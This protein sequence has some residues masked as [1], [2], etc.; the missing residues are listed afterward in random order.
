MPWDTPLLIPTGRKGS[1][2]LKNIVLWELWPHHLKPTST[3]GLIR[4]NLPKPA[5]LECRTAFFFNGGRQGSC[6]ETPFRSF[7]KMLHVQGWSVPLE[8]CR[9]PLEAVPSCVPARMIDFSGQALSPHV[10]ALV[11]A[12]CTA[13][14]CFR[15]VYGS[16]TFEPEANVLALQLQLFPGTQSP[17][18]NG[19][20]YSFKCLVLDLNIFTLKS[21][22][23]WELSRAD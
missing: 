23:T 3:S 2:C 22:Q 21:W 18:L 5:A 14:W 19:L 11:P 7:I 15:R 13:L 4:K 16:P 12:V 9:C 8:V 6:L 20:L 10:L 1:N 17:C